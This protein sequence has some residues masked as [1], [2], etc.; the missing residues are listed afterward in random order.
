MRMQFLGQQQSLPAAD[1]ALY[2]YVCIA[3]CAPWKLSQSLLALP[4][5][6]WQQAMHNNIIIPHA[7]AGVQALF[8]F[9]PANT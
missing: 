5:G 7:M 6:Y 1:H 8:L 2:M 4:S 9:A 3:E